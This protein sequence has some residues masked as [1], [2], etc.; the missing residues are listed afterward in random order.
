MKRHLVAWAALSLACAL[1]AH[2][3]TAPHYTFERGYPTPETSQRARDEADFQRAMIAYR[4]WY[5]TV[6]VEGIFNGNREKGIEDNKTMS[7]AAAGPRTVAFTANSDTPYGSG[8]LDVTN[9]PIVIELPAGPFIGLVNDHHQSWVL[10][11]GLP[12]PDAGTGGRHVVVPPGYRGQIPDGY[13]V[14]RSTSFKNLIAVRALPVGGDAK[15]AIEALRKIRIYPL[16]TGSSSGLMEFKDVSELKMDATALRW[17]D[18][19]QFWQVLD[20]IIQAEPLVQTFFPMYGLLSELGIEKGKTF[21]PDTRM[22][23]IL[24]RAAKAGRD[25]LL[26]SAFDSN[27]PDRINWPDRRWE[28]LGLVPDSVQFETPGGIDLEARDRWFAQAIVTSP[29][30]FNRRAGAGSLYWLSAR[31]KTGAFLD[32]GKNYKLTIP[33][34]VPGRLFWSVTV[35]DAATRSQVQTDQ[36]KAAL[37]SLVELKDVSGASTELYFGPNALAGHEAQWIKTTPGK[38]WFSYFRIYGPQGPA[39]DGSWKPGDFEEVK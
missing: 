7:I 14:G 2:A 4:F 30:M 10:D 36:D 15:G 17:E 5:P 28:W 18:N 26:V 6:S 31:D 21:A 24:E 25:Q 9:G 32:G 38:G 23:A 39:F 1:S 27:R 19:L 37:R 29:A 34:P 35:Y 20:R 13:N 16:A 33:Q 12:G 3:Q 11:M 8:V 22:Q